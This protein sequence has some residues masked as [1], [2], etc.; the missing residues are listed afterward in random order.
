MKLS[1][2]RILTLSSNVGIILHTPKTNFIV[3][4]IVS[5]WLL[6]PKSLE[7]DKLQK[8]PQE[9]RLKRGGNGR[10][11]LFPNLTGLHRHCLL[12]FFRACRYLFR[13]RRVP[14]P[15]MSICRFRWS[16]FVGQSPAYPALFNSTTARIGK[17]KQLG[18]KCEFSLLMWHLWTLYI[19]KSCPLV[20][21]K[22]VACTL[23]F[24]V[25]TRVSL[26]DESVMLSSQVS[27]YT[28]RLFVCK[29]ILPG[30]ARSSKNSTPWSLTSTSTATTCL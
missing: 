3:S 1:V 20:P 17:H 10:D 26:S 29:F 14:M 8:L 11:P 21:R 22:V 13:S 15:V 4:A 9:R 2:L 6:R 28:L 5:D 24:E 7:S 30:R 23:C 16:T 12:M 18:S 19:R 27:T 25:I